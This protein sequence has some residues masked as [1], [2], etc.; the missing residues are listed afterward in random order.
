MGRLLIRGEYG[1]DIIDE[2]KP[3][4]GEVV[5]DKPGKGLVLAYDAASGVASTGCYAFTDCGSYDGVLC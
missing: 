1:H 5:F 2:L 3:Y 4:P